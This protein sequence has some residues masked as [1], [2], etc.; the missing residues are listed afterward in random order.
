MRTEGRD[1]TLAPRA[2]QLTIVGR[3]SADK[4]GRGDSGGLRGWYDLTERGYCTVRLI[5]VCW[6]MVP[7]VAVTTT[8]NWPAGVG[9]ILLSP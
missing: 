6:V 3:R 9:A 1:G 7:A 8:G 4:Q 2:L 5:V